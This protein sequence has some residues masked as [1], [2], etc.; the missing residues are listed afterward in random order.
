MPIQDSANT[1]ALLISA[2]HLDLATSILLAKLET[3]FLKQMCPSISKK[4]V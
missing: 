1:A 3:S 4:K 2:I